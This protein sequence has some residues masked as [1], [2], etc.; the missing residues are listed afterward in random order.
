MN[1]T[2]KYSPYYLKED[3]ICL[4]IA[5]SIND[6]VTFNYLIKKDPSLIS[7]YFLCKDVFEFNVTK[8]SKEEQKKYFSENTIQDLKL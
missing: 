8:L 6:F 2:H 4:E 5:D 1:K 7:H 3:H